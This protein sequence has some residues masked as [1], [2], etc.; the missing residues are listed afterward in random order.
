MGNR[1]LSDDEIREIA[2]K[3]SEA[4][5]NEEEMDYYLELLQKETGLSNFSDYIF[6]PNEIGLDLDAEFPEIIAKIFE[7]MKR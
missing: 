5:Y 7:D 2:F 1:K 4:M 6:W 3:I